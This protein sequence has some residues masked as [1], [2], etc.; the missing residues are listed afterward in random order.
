M[1][2][3]KVSI[4]IPAYNCQNYI[5]ECLE[6]IQ[7]QTYKDK[8]IIVIDDG[9]TDDTGKIV[10]EFNSENIKYIYQ[11]NSGA[12]AA[13]N[14]GLKYATGKYIIFFDADDKMHKNMIETLVEKQVTSKAE[15]V[16]GNYDHIAENGKFLNKIEEFREDKIYDILEFQAFIHKISP[17]PDNKLFL[18][19]IIKE[20]AIQFA[21]VR[22]GQD[23]NFFLKYIV[24][25]KKVNI[26]Q[27]SL[28]EYRIV[29]NSISR[30]YD[31]RICDIIKSID[32]AIE[33][34]NNDIINNFCKTYN[35]VKVMHCYYQLSKCFYIVDKKEQVR[36]AKLLWEYTKK[37]IYGIEK[38]YLNTFA[39]KIKFII[40]YIIIKHIKL[41]K[42]IRRAYR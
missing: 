22:V 13:R 1:S 23:L 38:C 6:S 14:N 7:E 3:G 24:H 31:E 32:D 35:S 8:E 18:S 19:N 39:T 29:N 5:M 20:K 15:I 36:L 42:Y 41:K 2:N 17:F 21:D 11:E 28:C 34:T 26:I 4:I 33:N 10:S 16:I 27:D 30:K 25:V 12:P 40:K 37:S 9:S